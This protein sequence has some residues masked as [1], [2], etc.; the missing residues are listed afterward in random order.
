AAA[1]QAAGF[2]EGEEVGPVVAPHAQHDRGLGALG[3]PVPVLP[4]DQP[5]AVTAPVQPSLGA[6]PAA[7]CWS[8]PAW[9]R[10]SAITSVRALIITTCSNASSAPSAM[11]R[12]S[13]M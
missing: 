13:S 5:A 9:L 2:D 12:I 3:A 10:A 1:R 4:V 8:A 6:S 11:P 7:T